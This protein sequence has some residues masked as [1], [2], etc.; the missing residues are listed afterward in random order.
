MKAVAISMGSPFFGSVKAMR[1]PEDRG[2]SIACEGG[3]GVGG[4]M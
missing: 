4:K 3:G 1:S 2:F